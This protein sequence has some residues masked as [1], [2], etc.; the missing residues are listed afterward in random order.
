MHRLF[1]LFSLAG[2]GILVWA[3]NFPARSEEA[4]RHHALLELFE[5]QG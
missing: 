3:L 5:S 1:V 4:P 2:V